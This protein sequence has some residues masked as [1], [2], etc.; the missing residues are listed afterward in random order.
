MLN[1]LLVLNNLKKF[2]LNFG[3][4]HPAAHGVLRLNLLLSN[5]RVITC[6]PHIGLLHRNTETLVTTKKYQ[7][8]LPYFDR[9][10][11]VSML[12]QEH[13]YTLSIESL[14]KN[15]KINFFSKKIRSFLEEI[16]RILNHLLAIA[17]H[18]LDVGSMSI[19]FWAFE[20]RENCLT[21]YEYLSGARMHTALIRPNKFFY[22]FDNLLL[23]MSLFLLQNLPTTLSEIT[24]I[25]NLNKIW[26]SRLKN[27]GILKYENIKK[28]GVSG[29]LSRSIGVKQDLRQFKQSTYS[30]FKFLNF[31]SFFTKN[32][33]SLDRFNIRIY[34]ILESLNIVLTL[35]KLLNNNKKENIFSMENTITSFQYWSNFNKLILKKISFFYIESPKGTF[36]V[37]TKLN[38]L[39]Y[40]ILCKIKSPSYI[41]LFILKNLANGINLTDL[42]T[43]IGTIDIVF[44]EI[45]R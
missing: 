18:A 27:I 17:C 35:I 40:P 32:G 45:D 26:K 19:I 4:Q 22:N 24:S 11:Y 13:A 12:S 10:D 16:T 2:T 9:L 6:D 28:Y 39:N 43:L 38:N 31:Y 30:F 33:D 1:S 21:I 14:Y 34:E 37:V 5:E 23:D 41:N 7:L 25:L 20:E 36:G 44:G 8:S 15:N 3:P 29:V 42:V